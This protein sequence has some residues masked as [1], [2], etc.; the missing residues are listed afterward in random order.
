VI[1]GIRRPTLQESRQSPPCGLC[2]ARQRGGCSADVGIRAFQKPRFLVQV[3]TASC[4]RERLRLLVDGSVK[5]TT[6]EPGD[7]VK[8]R[9]TGR[10]ARIV[11]VLS[12]N[13]YEVEFLPEVTSDPL[14][15]DTVQSEQ[16]VG[17]YGGGD[18]EQVV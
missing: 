4:L 15:R 5:G 1:A 10:R 6:M 12:Q 13:R 16:E 14:D 18:L 9:L 7:I 2:Y 17:I 3:D 8:V 11:G